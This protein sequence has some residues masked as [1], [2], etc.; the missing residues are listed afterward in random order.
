MPG[1]S[2]TLALLMTEPLLVTTSI[3]PSI[4]PSEDIDLIAGRV[5]AADRM[6][7]PVMVQGR[8]PFLFLVDTG[9]QRTIL[10]TMVASRL[11]LPSGPSV[12][13]IGIAGAKEVATAYVEDITF[14]QQS[15]HGLTVP[16]LDSAHIG[17]DGI[18]GTDA[19]QNQRVVFDFVRETISMGSPR[20]VGTT[21]DYEIVVRAHR[22][23]GRLILSNALIDGVRTDV[24]I[25]TGAQGA[26]GNLALR[27]ALRGRTT[28]SGTL[29]SA[30][31][32]VQSADFRVAGEFKL[33]NMRLGN[34]VIA[35]SDGPA[36]AE[37]KLN[38]RPALFLGMQEMR[39]FKQIAVDFSTR[40]VFFNLG[41]P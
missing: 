13:V 3:P 35:F 29:T 32:Q 4:S 26:I 30:T 18:I 16:L 33:G 7:V 10:S 37:L 6:T 40:E 25:D 23:L 8:G 27:R 21:A 41:T 11:A 17:A 20:D 22:R 28:G 24:V 14:G 39:A 12:R 19:L 9:S 5:E 1:L 31:G 15:L 36:F 2:A 34:V 38:D